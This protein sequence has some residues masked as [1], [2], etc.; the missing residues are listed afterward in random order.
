MVSVPCNIV[1]SEHFQNIVK[2]FNLNQILTETD[3]PYLSPYKSRMNE[4]GF[5]VETIKIISKIKNLEK[6]EIEKII[7]KNYQNF[8]KW[9]GI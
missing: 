2:N 4:P 1:R 9:K 3:S 7:F 6:E 8:F 5:I